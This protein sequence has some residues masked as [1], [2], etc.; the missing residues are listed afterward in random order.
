MLLKHRTFLKK[1]SLHNFKSNIFLKGTTRPLFAYFRSSS[2]NIFGS[3]SKLQRDSN[4]DYQSRRQACAD[5]KTD[6]T[7]TREISQKPVFNRTQI[8]LFVF[9]VPTIEYISGWAFFLSRPP[10]VR[11]PLN[12]THLKVMATVSQ[13]IRFQ[14][15]NPASNFE[16]FLFLPKMRLRI[17]VLQRKRCRSLFLNFQY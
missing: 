9:L 12:R 5:L 4:S 13:I 3:N 16:H 8:C 15:G 14:T 1:N 2:D 10:L 11:T 6:T 17:A 7:T